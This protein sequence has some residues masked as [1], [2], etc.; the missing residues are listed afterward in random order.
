MT[1]PLTGTDTLHRIE[2]AYTDCYAARNTSTRLSPA[3]ASSSP[4]IARRN[5]PQQ[6]RPTST[7][8]L[9][10]LR[11]TRTSASRP[12]RSPASAPIR[13]RCPNRSSRSQSGLGFEDPVPSARPMPDQ[14]RPI[15]RTRAWAQRQDGVVDS[16]PLASRRA[17]SARHQDLPALR[18]HALLAL[19]H[20]ELPLCKSHGHR[21]HN[22]R[23]RGTALGSDIMTR[24][25]KITRL[26]PSAQREQAT[27]PWQATRV[28]GRVRAW[29]H[30][31]MKRCSGSRSCWMSGN[32]S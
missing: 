29:A 10:H 30:S 9:P 20:R 4:C 23:T 25:K 19:H 13:L 16:H 7:P 15:A 28:D 22:D 21:G 1:A 31:R 32:S 5:G 11:I 17:Q 8:R 27:T 24:L 26:H 14:S 2:C 12:W 3:L 18:L 6:T